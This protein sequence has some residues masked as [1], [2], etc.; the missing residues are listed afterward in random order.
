MKKSA[1]FRSQF[2]PLAL[3][4]NIQTRKICFW[5]FL[6]F[7]CLSFGPA[8]HGLAQSV[9]QSALAPLLVLDHSAG[10]FFVL[11][12]D[13]PFEVRKAEP[14]IFWFEVE[15][16]EGEH[17]AHRV[18]PVKSQPGSLPVGTYYSAIRVDLTTSMGQDYLLLPVVL[19]L[20]EAFEA[21]PYQALPPAEEIPV[22]YIRLQPND[23]AIDIRMVMTPAG[24]YI[25]EIVDKNK[26]SQNLQEHLHPTDGLFG[27]STPC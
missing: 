14:E 11:Y 3:I 18:V 5:V 27:R 23:S 16:I 2:R 9:E 12:S 24:H 17:T 8:G 22:E 19:Q 21:D 15:M 25:V 20:G 7:I 13:I 1:F 4:R 6:A 10:N 26:E